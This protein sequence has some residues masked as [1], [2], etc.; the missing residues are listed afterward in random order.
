[1]GRG[2]ELS[3]ISGPGAEIAGR[4][5]SLPSHRRGARWTP[6]AATPSTVFWYAV[7]IGRSIL[8]ARVRVGVGR[9]ESEASP[10]GSRR[11]GDFEAVATGRVGRLGNASVARRRSARNRNRVRRRL[12]DR[13]KV[14]FG[15]P[16]HADLAAPAFQRTGW[17][18]RRD[19]PVIG[20]WVCT[21]PDNVCWSESRGR[22][23]A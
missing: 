12:R 14:E 9:V 20:S 16:A 23:P 6:A 13:L 2:T 5:A 21:T 10:P 3:S 18:D 4:G 15:S 22:S 8:E 7:E 11:G 1:M 19:R 17:R